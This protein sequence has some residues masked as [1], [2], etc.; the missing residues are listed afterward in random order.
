MKGI[1]VLPDGNPVRRTLVLAGDLSQ[2]RNWCM[3]SQ[4]N[5]RSRNVCF[6][7]DHRQLLGL[8]DFDVVYTGTWYDQ[9]WSTRREYIGD[10]LIR[11]RVLGDIKNSYYQYESADIEPNVVEPDVL[12]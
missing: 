4:V 3:Y 10:T 7:H 9:P 1:P 8:N 2:F 12:G 6:V 5:P 11:H